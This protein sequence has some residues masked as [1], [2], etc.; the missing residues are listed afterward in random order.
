MTPNPHWT[1]RST[2]DFLYR[3]ATDFVGQIEQLMES[4]GVTQHEL[5]RQLSVTDGRISQL[6][7]NPGNL[8]L[9]KMV[10]YSRALGRKI[11]IVQYDD[12]DPD[13]IKGPVNSEIFA[14]CWE[15]I[16]SPHDF[17]ATRAPQRTPRRRG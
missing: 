9:R 16:G 17:F 1:A 6:L 8:T 13:R 12:E 10:E 4:E 7:N 2:D 14:K 3:I 5:A 11:A 15:R